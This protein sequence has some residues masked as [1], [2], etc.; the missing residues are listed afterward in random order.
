MTAA[1]KIAR[2]W[3]LVLRLRWRH[4]KTPGHTYSRMLI[5]VLVRFYLPCL[6]PASGA[7]VPC[8]GAHDRYAV[9]V[10]DRSTGKLQLLPV[11]GSK[12]LRMEARLHGLDYGA[13]Q[14][15]ENEP[16]TIQERLVLNKQ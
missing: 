7:P 8:F 4:K 16:T 3:P 15:V 10:Y 13:S 12:V 1:P 2:S 6:P 14:Y 11:Q 9:G 5:H